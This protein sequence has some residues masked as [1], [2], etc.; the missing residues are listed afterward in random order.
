METICT[1]YHYSEITDLASYTTKAVIS[2][3]IRFIPKSLGATKQ[4]A[5]PPRTNE[6]RGEVEEA[7]TDL[8]QQDS[9]CRKMV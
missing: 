4:T 3:S 1:R 6:V 9:N 2:V 5:L 7:F 8:Y